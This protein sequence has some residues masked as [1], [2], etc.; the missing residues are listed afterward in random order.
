[1]DKKDSQISAA[2]VAL[3]LE[4][5]AKKPMQQVSD[6]LVKTQDDYKTAGAL[7]KKVKEYGAL[8]KEKEE[9]F[10]I[11]LNKML[12][13]IK[14]LFK[15]FRDSVKKLDSDTK[16]KM[17]GFIEANRKK[18]EVLE[19]KFDS[20]EIKKVSTFIE[21]SAALEVNSTFSQLRKVWTMI[22]VDSTL[23]PKA[24]LCP[25]LALIKEALKAGKSVA[26]WKWEQV[27]SIAV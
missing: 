24:Y 5:S 11:P 27:N 16:E 12:A 17:L 7:L 10:T 1:M 19:A 15:P 4:K 22:E 8:A 23:T 3:T 26:G 25:D 9:T 13:D 2:I 18:V 20:G 14:E 21:K 6:L